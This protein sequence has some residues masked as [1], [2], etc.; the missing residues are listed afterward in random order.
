MAVS[1]WTWDN[2]TG[3]SITP[4]T[5]SSWDDYVKKHPDAKPFW[6][7]GWPHLDKISLIIL[8]VASGA[9]VFFPMAPSTSSEPSSQDTLE[10]LS[11]AAAVSK[12]DGQDDDEDEDEVCLCTFS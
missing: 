7:K 11:P 4:A 3:P 9:N 2:K 12:V 8:A 1:G 10:G 5:A 6:N